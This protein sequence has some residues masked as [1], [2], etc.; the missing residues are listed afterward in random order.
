M[1]KCLLLEIA[2]DQAEC[3]YALTFC[4]AGDELDKF[5]SEGGEDRWVI[6]PH[7]DIKWSLPR[8]RGGCYARDMYT[9]RINRFIAC[10]KGGSWELGASSHDESG[11]LWSFPGFEY[12][13]FQSATPHFVTCSRGEALRMRPALNQRAT[14]G[15]R[16]RVEKGWTYGMQVVEDNPGR[17]DYIS[18]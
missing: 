2:T 12:K 8:C 16:G 7:I 13:E 15:C 3:E 1:V 17:R 4:V 14:M 6:W 9:M 18:K 5:D 10:C 11:E